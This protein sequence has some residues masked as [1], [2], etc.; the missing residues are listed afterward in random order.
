MNHLLH[1]IDMEFAPYRIMLKCDVIIPQFDVH[2]WYTCCETISKWTN[3]DVGKKG[4]KSIV[5]VI[6]GS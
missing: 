6:P 3:I 5:L 1:S 2:S 4:S